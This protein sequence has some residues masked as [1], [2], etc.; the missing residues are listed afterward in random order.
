MCS[1]SFVRC[2]SE[3]YMTRS[4]V[5]CLFLI[6][7]IRLPRAWRSTR[8]LAQAVEGPPR[9]LRMGLT[10]SSTGYFC[11]SRYVDTASSTTSSSNS[12][13]ARNTLNPGYFFTLASAVSSIAV[14]SASCLSVSSSSLSAASAASSFAF[15]SCARA[16]AFLNWLYPSGALPM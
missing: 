10:S 14:F 15:S 3:C 2:Y 8:L 9:C 5:E 13:S 12:S 6:C 7:S 1:I 11:T 16:A 4:S